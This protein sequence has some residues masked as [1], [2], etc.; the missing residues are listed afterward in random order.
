MRLGM[1]LNKAQPLLFSHDSLLINRT[2]VL[3]RERGRERER[4]ACMEICLVSICLCEEYEV[5][6]CV[7]VHPLSISSLLT[8]AEQISQVCPEHV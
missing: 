2:C 4:R 5:R 8:S 3:L 1:M 7:C 6:L